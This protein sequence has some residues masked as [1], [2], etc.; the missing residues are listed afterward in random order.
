M[1][2]SAVLT[3][4]LLALTTVSAVPDFAEHTTFMDSARKVQTEIRLEN[5]RKQVNRE[6]SWDS[7]GV[8]RYTVEC[9]GTTF[10]GLPWMKY[11]GTVSARSFNEA[12][13]K[14]KSVQRSRTC[15]ERF[16]SGYG[17]D[18]FLELTPQ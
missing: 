14:A 4:L 3:T 11:S 10:S 2:I 12:H 16:G 17:G 15:Y 5:R 13:E 9:G 18:G 1:S 7:G 8:Y 6:A